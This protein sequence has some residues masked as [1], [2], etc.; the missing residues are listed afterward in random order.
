LFDQATIT[1]ESMPVEKA[2]GVLEIRADKIGRNVALGRI[3]EAVE[4]A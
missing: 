1:G 2:S 4:R 3:I